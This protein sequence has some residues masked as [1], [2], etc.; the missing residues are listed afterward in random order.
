MKFDYHVYRFFA[1]AHILFT[2]GKIT[3]SLD[4]TQSNYLDKLTQLDFK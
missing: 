3:C 4:Q 1:E 2:I